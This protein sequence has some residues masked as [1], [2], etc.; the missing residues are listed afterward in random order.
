M[1]VLNRHLH[2]DSVLKLIKRYGEKAGIQVDRPGRRWIGVHSLRK[3][4]ITDAIDHGA[5]LRDVL[6]SH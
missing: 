1:T 3:T 4:A 5:D 6:W 2:R